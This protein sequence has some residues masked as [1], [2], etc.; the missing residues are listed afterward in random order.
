M[1]NFWFTSPTQLLILAPNAT[2][3]TST[4][5]FNNL[6]ENFKNGMWNKSVYIWIKYKNSN[7]IKWT[8][9]LVTSQQFWLNSFLGQKPF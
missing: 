5:S 3:K 2:N 6:Q 9:K 4:Y 7:A 1:K 8:S